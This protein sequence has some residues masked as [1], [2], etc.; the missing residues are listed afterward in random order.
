[1]FAQ[2]YATYRQPCLSLSLAKAGDISVLVLL[3]A[4]YK[5]T[6]E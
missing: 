4:K 5:E 3:H 6:T 1:M 2:P